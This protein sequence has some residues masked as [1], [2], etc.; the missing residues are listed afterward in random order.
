MPCPPR[1]FGEFGPG[2]EVVVTAAVIHQP[3]LGG[4]VEDV[5][6]V[7]DH[8][9]RDRGADL[10]AFGVGHAGD[11]VLLGSEAVGTHVDE[12]VRAEVLHQLDH[13]GDVGL[14]GGREL[15]VLGPDPENDRRGGRLPF[16]RR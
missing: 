6:L 15:D 3:L 11:K 5:H 16:Q 7:K 12:L 13:P 4:A 10:E 9:Q 8:A 2:V 1:R 14:G